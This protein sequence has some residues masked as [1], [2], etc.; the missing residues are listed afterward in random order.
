LREYF[1][2]HG[3]L[4]WTQPSGDTRGIHSRLL[5]RNVASEA[6]ERFHAFFSDHAQE[7]QQEPINKARMCARSGR[8]EMASEYYQQAVK[9]QPWNWVLLNEASMFLTFSM[10]NPKR[11]MDMAKLALAL[12]PTC[13]ADLWSTLGDALYE[14]GRTTEARGAYYKA[15]AVNASDVRS[16]YN[17]AWVHTR[18]KDYAA[19]LVRIAEALALDKTGEYR[20]RLLQKLNEV[21]HHLTLRNQHEYLLLI[22]LVSKYAKEGD[23]KPEETGPAL[24]SR[25]AD[26]RPETRQ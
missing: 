10:R 26:E 19:A 13:S 15:M 1:A 6:V 12:N 17:L 5:S 25:P 7:K 22:N 23:K 24:T 4:R 8:F 11:G 16:R 3:K 2:E 20:D 18:E 14:F 21:M 9:E